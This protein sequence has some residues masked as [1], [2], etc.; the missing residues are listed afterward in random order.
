MFEPK[1]QPTYF[2]FHNK[3]YGERLI[4][5]AEIDR[6]CRIKFETDAQNDYFERSQY[7]GHYEVEVIDGPLE[8]VDLSHSVTIHNGIANWSIKLPDEQVGVGDQ[9]TIQCTVTD[10]TQINPFVNVATVTHLS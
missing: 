9:L 3:K 2:R 7:P 4:R 5:N 1:P 8:G 10:D 6:R